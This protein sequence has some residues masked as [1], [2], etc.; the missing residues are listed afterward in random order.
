MPFRGGCL[1][2]GTVA[3]NIPYLSI[4]QTKPDTTA[5]DHR[6]ENNRTDNPSDG[7]SATQRLGNTTQPGKA[8]V[9]RYARMP[10]LL[11]SSL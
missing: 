10:W 2:A 6:T 11:P 9:S 8:S 4:N 1:A 3:Q 5:T 7:A